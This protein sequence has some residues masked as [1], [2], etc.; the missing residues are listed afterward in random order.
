MW[1]KLFF[2]VCLITT[3]LV[4]PYSVKAVDSDPVLGSRSWVAHPGNSSEKIDILFIPWGFSDLSILPGIVSEMFNNTGISTQ[5]DGL[6]AHP[7]FDQYKERFNISFVDKNIDTAAFG[8][9][10]EQ[11]DPNILKWNLDFSCNN[12]EVKNRYSVFS[13]DYIV[14]IT[15]MGAGYNAW[16]GEIQYINKNR[17]NLEFTFVHE[18]GHQLGLADEYGQGAGQI[19][20]WC[21]NNSTVAD[22]N[23]CYSNYLSQIEDIPNLDKVGCPKWCESYDLN[24]ITNS[25]EYKECAP[26]TNQAACLADSVHCNW[27]DV[28]HPIFNVRCVP[29]YFFGSI[30]I[31]CK[32]NNQCHYGVHYGQLAF[33]SGISIMSGGME[34]NQPSI[35]HFNNIFKCC[36]PYTASN[37]CS[38][39]RSEMANVNPNTDYYM[40]LAYNKIST[41]A[42]DSTVVTPTSTPT[43]R[44]GDVNNDGHVNIVD[45]GEIIDYYSRSVSLDPRAD[46]N[47]DGYINII[48]IGIVIDNY[49]F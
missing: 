36:F 38:Q 42:S 48:D 8:C 32:N 31:N 29:N 27:F 46:L 17:S 11:P 21:G 47:N 19:G 6:F 35:D 33:S 39:F 4:L 10:Q 15:D 16:G 34:F 22:M 14:V 43:V 37:E 44:L 41:C 1:R 49:E 40:K 9:Y 3:T 5:E 7:P 18:F 25:N 24:I 45:I 30:G 2:A 12:D 23:A 26:I 20:Y 13:P 28:S